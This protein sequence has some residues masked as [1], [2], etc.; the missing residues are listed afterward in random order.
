MMTRSIVAP[1]DPGPASATDFAMD[2]PTACN[3]V[4]S[5]FYLYIRI[6]GATDASP[7]ARSLGNRQSFHHLAKNLAAYFFTTTDAARKRKR[8][9]AGSRLGFA[10]LEARNNRATTL[11]VV[12]PE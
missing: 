1:A 4:C 5:N 7:C 10:T 2:V 6:L 12:S 9:Q 3:R 8:T 11:R